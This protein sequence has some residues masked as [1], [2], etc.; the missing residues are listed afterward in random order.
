MPINDDRYIIEDAPQL[1]HGPYHGRTWPASL[2]QSGNV[3]YQGGQQVNGYGY[4]ADAPA[5]G[6]Q[7]PATTG[8]SSTTKTL[9]LVAAAI[10]FF[11]FILP[12]LT[13]KKRNPQSSKRSRSRRRR[14]QRD[15]QGRFLPQ[16]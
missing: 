7:V 5:P 4:G 14:K 13:G 1:G 6:S 12:K 9:I 8:M 11:V 10:I 2:V 3:A 15:S 16:E